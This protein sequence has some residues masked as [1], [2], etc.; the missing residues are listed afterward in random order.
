MNKNIY[1]LGY[2]LKIDTNLNDTLERIK[3]I[4]ANFNAEIIFED[5]PQKR[6]LAYPIKKQ[7]IGYFS[8]LIFKIDNKENLDLIKNNL[9]KISDILRLIIVKRKI[10][11]LKE[12]SN[13][14]NQLDNSEKI[15][16]ENQN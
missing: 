3:K 15:L 14:E 8:Y 4:L 10:I 13:K 1:E 2:W 6:N 11:S 9:F 12:K 5:V 7:T 16:I